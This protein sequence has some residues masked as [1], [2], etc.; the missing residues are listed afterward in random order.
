MVSKEAKPPVKVDQDKYDAVVE[1]LE[2]DFKPETITEITELSAATI[3]RIK[4][5]TSLEEYKKNMSLPR[6]KQRA[7]EILKTDELIKSTVSPHRVFNEKV[8][9][10]A[11]EYVWEQGN[12][13][14]AK[15]FINWLK[16][17]NSNRESK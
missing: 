10:L 16:N 6:R 8:E 7:V 2:N 5:S 9:R 15:G 4:N 1:F 14:S 17:N 11:K 13:G 3:N 12:I